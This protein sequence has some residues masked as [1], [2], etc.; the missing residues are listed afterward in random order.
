MFNR[1]TNDDFNK[2]SWNGFTILK[3]NPEIKENA[4]RK[5]YPKAI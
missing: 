2:F 3:L 4:Y 1:G 5:D